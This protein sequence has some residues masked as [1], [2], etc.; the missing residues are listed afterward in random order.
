MLPS[1]VMRVPATF[2]PGLLVP[3][4]TPRY[5]SGDTES[6]DAAAMG[7]NGIRSEP[8]RANTSS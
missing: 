5:Q 1:S 2:T 6:A 7:V 4:L 8:C 3:I